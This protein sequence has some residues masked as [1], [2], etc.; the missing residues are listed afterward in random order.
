MV[1]PAILLAAAAT[2]IPLAKIEGGSS[3]NIPISDGTK[4]V[5]RTLSGDITNN[6]TG[7][8]TLKN[9]G[10]AGT[11]GDA[12]HFPVITTDA[13]GRVTVVTTNTVIGGINIADSE[14]PSGTINA[15]NLTFTLAHTPVSGSLKLYSDGIRMSGGGVDYTL[16]TAT[17]TFASTD[18][19]PKFT[20]LA[21]YRY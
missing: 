5:S 17:I 18:Q 11:Y 2:Y 1:A 13:Q 3:A 20:L 6:S 9:T 10:T 21:D 19:T 7:V 8:T 15:S 16:S 14:I 12:T 4:L